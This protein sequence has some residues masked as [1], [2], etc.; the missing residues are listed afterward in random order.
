MIS[1]LAIN[2]LRV[3]EALGADI[4]DLGL[5]PVVGWRLMP[6]WGHTSP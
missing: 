3:S 4:D 5:E 2:G 6:R 1:L